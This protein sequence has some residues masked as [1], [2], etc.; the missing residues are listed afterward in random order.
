MPAGTTVSLA[1]IGR[2]RMSLARG[3][4]RR[5]Q[6][7]LH[8]VHGVIACRWKMDHWI[9]P[10]RRR[11]LHPRQQLP[12]KPGGGVRCR[13]SAIA[14][15]QVAALILD[16]RFNPG[17]FMHQAVIMAD[18]FLSDGLILSTVNRRS[19]IDEFRAERQRVGRGRLPCRS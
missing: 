9:D 11:G 2:A 5:E 6:V 8:T 19:A 1:T 12:R 17:G 13:P 7:S 4:L 10:G 18:R 16:L 15:D 14:A 3:S